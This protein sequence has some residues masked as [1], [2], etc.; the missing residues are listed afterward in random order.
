MLELDQ[1]RGRNLQTDQ[2]R[3]V[4]KGRLNLEAQDSHQA[5][6][7]AAMA[8]VAPNQLLDLL[9]RRGPASVQQERTKTPTQE[10]RE[11][12]ATPTNNDDSSAVPVAL[13]VNER[14]R[15]KREVYYQ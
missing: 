1:A 2:D 13:K 4:R 9:E 8:Q 10:A 11:K 3:V 6:Q 14:V 7:R 12:A 15:K 5:Q